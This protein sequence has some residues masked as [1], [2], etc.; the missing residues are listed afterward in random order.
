MVW[1]LTR[2]TSTSNCGTIERNGELTR[3]SALC[4]DALET[5]APAIACNLLK[6]ELPSRSWTCIAKPAALPMPWIGGGGT[7]RIRASSMTDS[8]SFK[9]TNSDR[10]SSPWPRALHSFS[11]K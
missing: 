9:P 5:M 7:T 3:C 1:A 2:S 10:R 11:I 4:V 8:F 6:S